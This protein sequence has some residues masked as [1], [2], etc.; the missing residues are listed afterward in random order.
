MQFNSLEFLLLF[1][2]IAVFSFIASRK[3][4][5]NGTLVFLVVVS[6]VYYMSWDPEYLWVIM[7]SIGFNFYCGNLLSDP[8]RSHIKNQ[9]ILPF[10]I[11]VNLGFMAYFKYAN[12]FIDNLSGLTG[13]DVY[14]NPIF[15]PIAI[16][17]F[18]FQQIAYLIDVSNGLIKETRFL[19]YCVFITFFPQL[20]AGPVVLYREMMPQFEKPTFGLLNY[21]NISVGLTIFSVGIFKK[22]VLADGIEIYSTQVFN[23]AEAGIALTFFEAWGGALAYTFQIYFD[24][25][26]YSDMAIGLARIFGIV[27]PLNFNSPFKATNIIEFWRRWHMSLTR[28]F[29]HYL[30]QPLAMK[31]M[32]ISLIRK[33]NTVL[34]FFLTSGL[35]VLFVFTLIGLWHG[36]SWTY[37]AFG[38]FHGVCIVANLLWQLILKPT[39]NKIKDKRVVYSWI[40]WAVTFLCVMLSFVVFRSESFQGAVS[41]FESMAGMHGVAM[42]ASYFNYLNLIFPL[43]DWLAASG[44]EFRNMVYLHGAKQ[45]GALFVLGF[46]VFF[47]PNMQQLMIN[48]KPALNINDWGRGISTGQWWQWQPKTIIAILVSLFTL[49]SLNFA[50]HSDEKIFLYYKF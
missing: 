28:F 23:A 44:W 32:R 25:S 7:C 50:F 41:I 35:P 18:T 16:S 27:L 6:L 14:L 15:L 5:P 12:F 2:P 49:L 10:G 26:G 24:F 19:D 3:L 22:V 1:L 45:I 42:H 36:A 34:F 30:Y 29:T 39:E 43:G 37:V 47:L 13:W 21:E 11:I 31:L 38:L 48:Y 17:F 9:F 40:C 46:I 4:R 8:S 33:N 20:V